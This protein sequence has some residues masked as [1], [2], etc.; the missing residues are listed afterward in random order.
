MKTFATRARSL[1]DIFGSEDSEVEKE[2]MLS[3][4]EKREEDEEEERDEDLEW[5]ET[6]E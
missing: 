3:G 4:W 1:R 5:V 6:G 2:S